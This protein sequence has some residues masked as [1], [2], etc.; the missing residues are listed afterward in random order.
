MSYYIDLDADGFGDDATEIVDCQSP[1]GDVW[2]TLGGDCDDGL[3]E[4]NPSEYDVCNGID[5]N[6]DDAIDENDVYEDWWP[7]G[8]GD[9]FGDETAVPEWACLGLLAEDQLWATTG[10]D[11]DDTNAFVYPGRTEVCDG[12]DQDC[13]LGVDDGLMV[14]D[15]WPDEDGDSFGDETLLPLSVCDGLQAAD[16]VNNDL[17]CNDGAPGVNPAAVE[18]CDGIDQDCALGI[19]DGLPQIDWWPDEDVDMHGDYWA[20]PARVCDGQQPPGSVPNDC[21]CDDDDYTLQLY[22]WGLDLDLDG[23]HSGD[24]ILGLVTRDQCEQP[25]DSVVLFEVKPWT[26]FEGDCNNGD[27]LI[28]PDALEVCNDGV[29]NSCTAVDT[30][31]LDGP[32]GD[33]ALT[34]PVDASTRF[35]P[36]FLGLPTEIAFGAAIGFL[37]DQNADGIDEMLIASPDASAQD[38]SVFVFESPFTADESTLPIDVVNLTTTTVSGGFGA[39]VFGVR[40]MTSDG[41]ADVVVA[42]PGGVG[43][44]V[45]LIN[46]TTTGGNWGLATPRLTGVVGEGVGSHVAL[47]QGLA[48]LPVTGQS[49]LIGA[50]GSNGVPAAVYVVHAPILTADD[51]A[52]RADLTLTIDDHALSLVGSVGDQNGDGVT[53]VVVG[54]IGPLVTDALLTVVDA[55]GA[56][57]GVETVQDY[58]V[59]ELS[60]EAELGFSSLARA[61]LDGDGFLDLVVGVPRKTRSDGAL[62]AGA[63]YVLLGPVDVTDAIENVAV[64]IIE[65]ETEDDRFGDSLALGDIDGDGVVDLVV[66]AEVHGGT[67][68]A[69][70]QR[71][72]L[73]VGVAPVL[74][75]NASTLETVVAG[76][77]EG[78]VVGFGGDLTGDGI[79]DVVLGAPSSQTAGEAFI[80][81]GLGL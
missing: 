59:G 26:R 76:I 22:T 28:H 36:F 16:W 34:L 19:D 7:D 56:G 73:A 30:C 70:V 52:T 33:G 74:P 27:D 5:D 41:V 64:L 43:G 6:C 24:S 9:M 57:G 80:I 11:C 20:L 55:D 14:F 61:D 51:I 10:G 66:G 69:Y 62:E 38:G 67:G 58:T 12:V 35:S 68:R 72:P 21:D 15:W 63:V 37:P 8:D 23:F 42:E 1:D 49:L 50:R 3:P 40:D 13:S 75:I 39:T 47:V 32:V 17:D 25:P 2:V 44:T 81:E 71:G 54:H 78:M 29:D 18:V 4:V 48:G 46:A 31:W 77:A 79:D 60:V 65:G 45:Y 53:D